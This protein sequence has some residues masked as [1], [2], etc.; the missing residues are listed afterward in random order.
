L[1]TRCNTAWRG[2]IKV[3]AFGVLVTVT[4]YTAERS[5]TSALCDF[6]KDDVS[7]EQLHSKIQQ[8]LARND[9]NYHTPNV[10]TV[11]LI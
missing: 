8:C 9:L 11:E 6:Y 1:V 4:V 5:S 2:R 3:K 10:N 7:K